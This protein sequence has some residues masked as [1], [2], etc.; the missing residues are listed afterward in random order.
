MESEFRHKVIR[1]SDNVKGDFATAAVAKSSELRCM[2]QPRHLQ[3]R[4]SMIEPIM[5]AIIT[6]LSSAL[7]N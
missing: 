5:L 7:H 3:F 1:Q 4:E 2:G 6:C